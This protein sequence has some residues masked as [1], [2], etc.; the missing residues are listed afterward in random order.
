ML[1][2]I[3]NPASDLAIIF[4]AVTVARLADRADR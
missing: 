2:I 4:R 1:G 3:P